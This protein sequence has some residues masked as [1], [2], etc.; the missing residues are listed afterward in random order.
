MICPLY[1]IYWDSYVLQQNTCLIPRCC[2]KPTW[3]LCDARRVLCPEPWCLFLEL[4]L[5]VLLL[6]RDHTWDLRLF[7]ENCPRATG[8][9]FVPSHWQELKAHLRIYAS[10][11]LSLTLNQGTVRMLQLPQSWV[12]CFGVTYTPP[13]PCKILSCYD[14]PPSL[15]STFLKSEFW[16]TTGHKG[17]RKGLKIWVP[18]YGGAR[19]GREYRPLTLQKTHLDLTF[20][21]WKCTRYYRPRGPGATKSMCF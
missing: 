11:F 18:F 19:E 20:I 15:A 14:N 9:H 3:L 13:L 6:C 4:H 7:L 8:G 12:A 1:L 16:K 10:S 2:L 5:H 17:F 21:S